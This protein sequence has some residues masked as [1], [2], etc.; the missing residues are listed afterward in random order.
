MPVTPDRDEGGF[1]LPVVMG[2]M[3]V[4]MLLMFAAFSAV[5][6]DLRGARGDQD[7]KQARSAAEAGVA[8]FTSHLN[9]DPD[10]WAKCTS[11]PA[12]NAVNQQWDGNGADPRSYRAVPGS[13]SRYAIELLP[14]NG[15]SSCSKANAI[16][17]MIDRSTKSLRIRST[18]VIA[19]EKR[20]L[21]ASYRRRSFLD[22]LYFTDYETLDP[23]VY[24]VITGGQPTV[25]D[26]VDWANKNC[27]V[28]WRDGRGSRS[29]YNANPYARYYCS[30]IQFADGDQ[31]NGPLHTNDELLTSGTPIFGRT[32][33]DRI[34][35][36]APPKGYRGGTP[37]FKGTFSTNAPHL[38]L[39]PS[40]TQVARTALPAYTF[41]G[42]TTIVLN[43]SSMTV[44]GANMAL[45]SNGVISVKNGACGV[46]G[47]QIL[48]PYNDPPG[49][50]D[51]YV[52]GT[53]AENL[54]ITSDKDVVVTGDLRRSGDVLIG[55][56][57][58]GFVR[59]FHPTTAPEFNG[60]SWTCVNL[61][62]TLPNVTIE[63]AILSLQHSFI[64]DNYFCGT[65]LGFL[66]VTGS[67]SQ[68][69][70]GPVGTSGGGGGTG[71]IKRY[72]Y[73]DRLGVRSPPEFLD[74]VQSA[75][76]LNRLTE[77]LPPR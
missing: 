39:P 5:D 3:M 43:G 28:Y 4:M 33:Q 76:R 54:T 65:K 29:Y 36:Q 75:W 51:A 41:S 66:T 17:S 72:G 14:A 7:S 70:R 62:G 37:S 69:F 52:Q 71:Y 45:P 13:T 58:T 35:V 1:T 57:A 53:S 30:E 56:I 46:V 44:N 16:G 55:L 18:G 32:V 25:P 74:P 61:P 21:I 11:V 10:Y 27:A 22:Y 8:D 2:V 60:G 50:A 31:V 77:Q 68:K 49:C 6:G 40:N 26:V 73:D 47:Y 63:A 67:I 48:A 59:V 9:Q 38:E 20:S 34:E 19:N 23:S 64:V 12:P 24:A 42:Q 15:Q